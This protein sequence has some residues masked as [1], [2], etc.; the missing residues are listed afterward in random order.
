MLLS[1]AEIDYIT[2]SCDRN[3]RTDG[4]SRLDLRP[5][6]IETGL[7][8]Q[9]NGSC[10][11]R[12]DATDVVVGVKAEIGSIVPERF[13]EGAEGDRDEDDAEVVRDVQAQTED[14][15]DGA[16]DRGRVVCSV[17]CA[18]SAAPYLSPLAL[19]SLSAELSQSVSRLLNGPGGG[20]DLKS[21]CII[22]RRTCWVLYV[23]AM[24]LDSSG[25]L[26]DPLHLA[27]RAALLTTQIPL[28]TVQ[29]VGTGA[30]DLDYDVSADRTVPVNGAIGVPVTVTLH[31][32]GTRLIADPTAQ[33]ERCATARVTVHVDGK[34]RVCGVKKGGKGGLE[35]GL[36]KEA[37]RE[38]RR[39]G[40][41]VVKGLDKVLEEEGKGQ[42]VGFFAA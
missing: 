36:V 7:L 25:H 34:G 42:R 35:A 21:L 9:A 38:G 8:A 27:V 11:L 10:R 31:R 41:D 23:D 32:V 14:G 5:F 4:R 6:L 15:G 16:T 19:Q 40:L 13:E 3:I 12:V 1:P 28:V 26:L 24:I 29:R 37:V 2:K 39:V 17:D 22:P 33:E 18:P 20:L 30:L